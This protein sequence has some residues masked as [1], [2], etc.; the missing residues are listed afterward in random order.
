MDRKKFIKDIIKDIQKDVKGT[1]LEKM[2]KFLYPRYDKKKKQWTIEVGITGRYCAYIDEQ[3]FAKEHYDV[4][5]DIGKD[6]L[7]QFYKKLNERLIH[8]SDKQKEM[9]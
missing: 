7:S 9:E 1:N 3:D 5:V 8:K 2:S 4:W 6:V